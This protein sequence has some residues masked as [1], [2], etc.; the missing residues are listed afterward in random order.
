MVVQITKEQILTASD[1]KE[2]LVSVTYD[3]DSGVPMDAELSV[4]ELLEGTQAYDAYVQKTAEML[5]KEVNHFAFAHAFDIKLVNPETGEHYQ[6]TKPVA[7]S[8]DLYKEDV[9]EGDN[10]NVVHFPDSYAENSSEGGEMASGIDGEV[11]GSRGTYTENPSEGEILEA[12]VNGEVV[13]FE[14]SSFS[15]YVVTS[16]ALLQHFVF[17]N[18]S[19]PVADRFSEQVL[20]NGEGLI[21]APNATRDGAVFKHWSLT[22]GG[23]A[24]DFANG[25]YKN[26]SITESTVVDE[27]NQLT[28]KAATPIYLNT[29]HDGEEGWITVTEANVTKENMNE[30]LADHPIYL[31]AVYNTAKTVV[32]FY[33]QSGLVVQ[34]VDVYKSADG[35]PEGAKVGSLDT[36]DEEYRYTPIQDRENTYLDFRNWT[37]DRVATTESPKAG[38]LTIDASSPAAI[39]LYPVVVEG[40]YLNFETNRAA[41]GNASI[42]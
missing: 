33:N 12:N 40:H 41:A 22:E 3:S 27:T 5:G 18:G 42:A 24:Y 26:V 29:K 1:G 35:A 30:Y 23:E 13:E 4:S 39:N 2:Y 37:R 6:P 15:V 31:H 34:K 17:L 20:A 28:L 38:T 32:T 16:D 21:E 9:Q 8:I 25:I 11:G 10:V 36:E 19:D 7:V 14:A